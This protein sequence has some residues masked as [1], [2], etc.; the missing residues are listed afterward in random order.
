MS[1]ALPLEIDSS[2]PSCARGL[3]RGN[4]RA[5][6][7]GVV[8][9]HHRL[10]V[11]IVESLDTSFLAA[12]V[13]V[14][15]A[16][17]DNDAGQCIVASK[18]HQ[19]SPS[20][21]RDIR[22]CPPTSPPRKAVA[23]RHRQGTACSIRIQGGGKLEKRASK[24][25]S[26]VSKS[27]DMSPGDA[28]RRRSRYPRPAP[29]Q[30]WSADE[31]ARF[32]E[33]LLLYG[34]KWQTV[35]QHVETKTIQQTR[36]HAQKYFKRVHLSGSNEFVPAPIR[37]KTSTAHGE[38]IAHKIKLVRCNDGTTHLLERDRHPRAKIWREMATVQAR[39]ISRSHTRHTKQRRHTTTDV[40]W[41]ALQCA[42]R[43]L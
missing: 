19:V 14:V 39:W 9:A 26:L 31:H 29:R 28:K 15:A 38:S 41:R 25:T 7:I 16:F 34:R 22:S 24:T 6:A 32:K 23:D 33:A 2:V 36:S 17:S 5:T 12:T 10:G 42:A 30:I 18:R 27:I 43:H 1:G 21:S 3:A 8:Q 40:N 4:L 11:G 35:A 20:F 37:A 13:D